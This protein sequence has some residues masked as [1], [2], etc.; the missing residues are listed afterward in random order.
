[1][2]DGGAVAWHAREQMELAVSWTRSA[3]AAVWMPDGVTEGSAQAAAA[4]GMRGDDGRVKQRML[5]R[6]RTGR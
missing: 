3:V 5:Q 2:V 1:M 6:G 4:A